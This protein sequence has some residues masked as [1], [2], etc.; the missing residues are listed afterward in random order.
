LVGKYYLIPRI[1]SNPEIYDYI[2]YNL[3]TK[4]SESISLGDKPISKDMYINGIYE[5][6]LY[7]VDRS[8]KR[9][10][11]LDPRA[12]TAVEV[13]NIDQ[14]G[15]AYLNGKLEKMSMYQLIENNVI[16]TEKKGDFE[17]IDADLIYAQSNYAYYLKNGSFYKVYEGRLDSPICLFNTTNPSHVKF[18][19]NNI[20]FIEDNKLYKYNDYGLNVLISKD[21]F[22]YHSDDFYDIYI[23]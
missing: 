19:N 17:S 13:G 20:Y 3:E 23:N 16:F 7:I 8:N 21:E 22:R 6:S 4:K 14:D 2:V 15:Y 12:L 1:I 5:G 11:K 10:F 18:R 9:Q